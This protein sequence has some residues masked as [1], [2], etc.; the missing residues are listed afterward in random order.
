MRKCKHVNTIANTTVQT[1]PFKHSLVV[2]PG[3]MAIS[4]FGSTIS[5][6]PRTLWPAKPMGSPRVDSADFNPASSQGAYTPAVT[7][8]TTPSC[9]ARRAKFDSARQPACSRH[10]VYVYMAVS[11]LITFNPGLKWP[12]CEWASKSWIWT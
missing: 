12:G 10:A 1:H 11:L 5:K 3:Q 8:H 6:Q 7:I 4:L 9:C 2:V